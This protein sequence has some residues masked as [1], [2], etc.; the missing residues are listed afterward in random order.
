[1]KEPLPDYIIRGLNFDKSRDESTYEERVGKPD[2]LSAV[3]GRIT[4]KFQSL[5]N[6]I[7]KIIIERL[8]EIDEEIGTIITAELSYKNKVNLFASLYY[9]FNKTKAYNFLKGYENEHF[10]LLLR[11]L[12]KSEDLRNQILHSNIWNNWKTNEIV[13]TKKTS[14]SKSGLKIVN[15]V[16][17][18]PYLFDVSDFMGQVE[19]NL[20]ECFL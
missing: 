1:M 8:L 16:V 2:E 10:K 15:Q 7:D 17:D 4:M 3:M 12:Y 19:Y 18:I 13:R 5:E 20:E 11:A 14:K 6:A 9:K